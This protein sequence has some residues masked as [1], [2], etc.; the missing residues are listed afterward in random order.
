[1]EAYSEIYITFKNTKDLE[2]YSDEYAEK[3]EENI[4]YLEE[5][6]SSR[7]NER[8]EE[9]KIKAI[10][11]IRKN[12]A[13]VVESELYLSM[14]ESQLPKI[15]E[16]KYYFFDRNDNPGYSEFYDVVKRIN[17]IATVFPICFF[18]VAV[19]ICLTTMTRMV[20]ENRIEIGTLK[21]LGYSNMEISIKYI[22]YASLASIIGGILGV[23]VGFNIFPRVIYTAY[24]TQYALPNLSIVYYP[25]YIIQSLVISILCT[26]GA[27]LLVLKV[28][29][30]STP[31][32]LMR[33]KAPKSGKRILLERIT[34]I[35]KRL[36]FN[37][38][39]TFRN[40][41]R[42]KQRMIMTVFGIAACTAMIITGFG[43]KDS[44]GD[45][46]NKQ[47][48]KLWKYQATVIFNDNTTIEDD[49]EYNEKLMS[50]KGYKNSL[51]IHQEMVTISKEDINKQNVT[52]YVP[53]DK[54][55]FKDFVLLND[56]VSGE[57]YILSDDSAIINEK[58]AKLLGVVKGDEITFKD[59]ENNS[60]II[61]VSNI[62]ESYLSHGIYMSKAYYVD[63][64]GKEAKYNSQFIMLDD[65]NYEDN[66]IAS[67]LMETNKVINVTMTSYLSKTTNEAMDTL[68]IV[69]IILIISAGGL[70]LVVLYNLNN[71][72]V[73]ERI[74]EL[75]TIKVLG[76]YDHEVTM[77]ILRE[78]FILTALG[79]II[80][81]FMGKILHGFVITTA[82]ADNMMLS[83]S[84]YATSFIYSI[85]LTIVFSLIV[86]FMMHRKLKKIN[87]IDALK[88]NE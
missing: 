40:L 29:L 84:I 75:S 43:L 79:I 19:L 35:W 52:L 45:L 49:D 28:D 18:I 30:N 20:E 78:N 68:N 21:A 12:Y 32:T 51:N 69:V 54:D 24:N 65:S 42:Y 73:S 39:V 76:F 22:I 1:M 13:D 16:V 37:Q 3:M 83:P 34:P 60:Y 10:E 46:T 25:S 80:G 14:A 23:I 82:E 15:D 72:N 81:M 47:F 53:E 85:I 74:R 66:D 63:V 41:F 7:P 48:N 59:S 86:M 71:I 9:I 67:K 4:R 8:F 50:L 5:L 70:A 55:K 36:N 27:S 56:R 33:P 17:S 26:V 61:K 58:L 31:S 64:F 38:K 6:F 11:E 77:Y 44:I 57:E 62:S 87:M 88:S 2:S